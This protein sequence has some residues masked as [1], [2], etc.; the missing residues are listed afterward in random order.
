MGEVAT[1]SSQ[2]M[3]NISQESV[4]QMLLPA[5]PF[6]EQRRIAQLLGDWESVIE[7]TEQLIPAKEDRFLALIDRLVLKPASGKA[8]KTQKLRDIATRVQRR[9]DGGGHPVLT[10]SNASGFVLQEE[11]YKRY[12]AGESVIKRSAKAV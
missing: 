11:K 5:P 12:M 9:S 8:W 4:L 6:A 10:I 2:S 7:K 1:G 3:K